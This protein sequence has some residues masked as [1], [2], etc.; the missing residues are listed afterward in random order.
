MV[1]DRQGAVAQLVAHQ[2]V[3]RQA[4]D[5]LVIHEVVVV[6]GGQLGQARGLDQLLDLSRAGL[7]LGFFLLLTVQ[8]LV[9]LDLLGVRLGRQAGLGVIT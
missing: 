6:L 3:D 5:L 9:A 7:G 8:F 1:H 4:L 2:R